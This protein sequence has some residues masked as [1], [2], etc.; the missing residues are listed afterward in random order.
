M[1][2]IGIALLAL[3]ALL[4][5]GCSLFALFILATDHTSTGYWPLVLSFVVPGLLVTAICIVL[6]RRLN[7]K[8]AGPDVGP[9]PAP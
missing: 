2:I 5:G 4:C 8:S 1:K 7:R 3:I 6:I 9:P